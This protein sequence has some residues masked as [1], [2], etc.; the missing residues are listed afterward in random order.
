MRARD[1][2]ALARVVRAMDGAP[3]AYMDVFTASRAGATPSRDR[4]RNPTP[5]R[6]SLS[7]LELFRRQLMPSQQF[8]EVS[9]VALCQAGSLANVATRDLKDL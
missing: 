7:L 3:E 2:V 8:V 9:A 4:S 1:G 5:K 6:W